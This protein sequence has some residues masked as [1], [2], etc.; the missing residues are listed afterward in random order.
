MLLCIT[1]TFERSHMDVQDQDT[2]SFLSMNIILLGVVGI[3]V[4][5]YFVLL[6]RKRWQKNFLH[7]A[8]KRGP[9]EK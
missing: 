3:I 4:F 9:N 2:V 5:G 1:A 8:D 7:D 6:I